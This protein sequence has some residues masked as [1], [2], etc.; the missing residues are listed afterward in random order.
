M[1]HFKTTNNE[2]ASFQNTCSWSYER[3]RSFAGKPF[4]QEKFGVRSSLMWGRSS[5][6]VYPPAR[7]LWFIFSLLSNI[8]EHTRISVVW[9]CFVKC[10]VLTNSNLS[11]QLYKRLNCSLFMLLKFIFSWWSSPSEITEVG[12]QSV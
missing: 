8:S 11:K 2:N 1:Y 9:R 7:D 5:N 4:G 3:L 6:G 12:Q 10:D